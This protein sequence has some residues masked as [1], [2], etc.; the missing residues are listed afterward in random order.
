MIQ[1]HYWKEFYQLKTH[2]NYVELHLGRTEFIDRGVK[3]FLALTSSGSIGAWVVWKDYAIVWGF[4]IAASQVLNVI[5]GYLPYKE[6]L[7]ALAGL[8]VDLEELALYVEMKW[9]EIADGNM[10]EQEIAKCLTDVRAR[11]FKAIKKHFPSSVIPE[12]QAFLEKAE[13]DAT[14]SLQ[15]FYGSQEI[16]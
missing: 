16:I 2:I 15:V 7:R 13:A 14:T 6:R 1:E 8:L 5:R 12:N 4:I 9:L 11:K 10:T 3:M